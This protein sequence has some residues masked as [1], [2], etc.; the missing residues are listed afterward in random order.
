MIHLIHAVVLKRAYILALLRTHQL[1]HTQTKRFACRVG[2]EKMFGCQ[3]RQA[4]IF[5]CNIRHTECSV[6]TCR[7]RKCLV[8]TYVKE[9]F[10]CHSRRA[11]ACGLNRRWRATCSWTFA[12]CLFR[13]INVLRGYVPPLL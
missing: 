10:G 3:I 9:I 1:P 5:S 11:R 12:Q 13:R 6:A 2:Q 4:K 7:K 8:A